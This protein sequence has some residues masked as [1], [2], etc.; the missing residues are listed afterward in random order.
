MYT[1]ACACT[2]SC[3]QSSACFDALVTSSFCSGSSSLSKILWS[4]KPAHHQRK[5]NRVCEGVVQRS[6]RE[7]DEEQ[8]S[9]TASLFPWK[10]T[11]FEKCCAGSFCSTEVESGQAHR[12]L[13]MALVSRVCYWKGHLAAVSGREQ[14][15][16]ESPGVQGP[17]RGALTAALRGEQQSHFAAALPAAERLT[18]LPRTTQLEV[19]QRRT[20]P[21]VQGCG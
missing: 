9:G 3:T 8:V 21:G 1:H 16:S 2:P 5:A 15:G 20:R 6:E 14:K 4:E 7:R 12:L 13:L 17:P 11:A 10:A 18:D 19:G